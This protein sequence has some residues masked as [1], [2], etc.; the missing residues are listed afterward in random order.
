MVELYILDTNLNQIDVIDEYRS[1]LWVKRYTQFGDCE[2]YIS[3]TERTISSLQRGHFIRR[4]DDDMI[5]RIKSVTLETDVEEGDY[6]IVVG[7]DCRSILNQ[8][9]V[10]RQTS[11]RGT[12]ERLIRRLIFDNI[13]NPQLDYDF[14]RIPN[15]T[16]AEMKGFTETM[17]TQV[18][19][20]VVGEKI[21]EICT[22]FGYGSRVTFDG[23]NFIFDLYKGEDRS[24]NQGENDFVVFSPEFENLASSNYSV[25]ESNY[26]SI[27]LIGGEGEGL[28]RT[29]TTFAVS[30]NV[31]I[32]RY[33]IFVDADGISKTMSYDDLL[34]AYPDGAIT[35]SGEKYYWTV[36]GVNIA[37]LDSNTEPSEA[38]LETNIYY[39]LLQAQG[40][41]TLS[42][43]VIVT[44]FDGEVEPY[45]SY[46]YGEDYYLGDIVTV[47]NE[48]GIESSARITEVIECFDENGYSLVPTF[49]YMEV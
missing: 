15:F 46:K 3:A 6:L 29:L 13:I 19:Y 10:W 44:S 42:E 47:K 41:D 49:E 45:H 33:E 12:A 16:I 36:D 8:R 7:E 40:Q 14:R 2:I 21:I 32:N 5:C 48:Y 23:A 31:G 37:V 9:I 34:E 4:D 26:K 30:D 35:S 20:D 11:F 22:T 43:H 28:K 24:Y 38:T 1:L 17:N 25:D 27:A 18:S 39:E